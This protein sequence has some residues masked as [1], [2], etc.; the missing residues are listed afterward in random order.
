[1]YRHFFGYYARRKVLLL[2]LHEKTVR[3]PAKLRGS[4]SSTLGNISVRKAAILD[5]GTVEFNSKCAGAHDHVSRIHAARILRSNLQ[6]E[7]LAIYDLRHLLTEWGENANI[8]S[9][10]EFGIASGEPAP[11]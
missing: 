3:F 6:F 4:V 7:V 8:R 9:E 11:S 10:E 2:Q 5:F 1:M